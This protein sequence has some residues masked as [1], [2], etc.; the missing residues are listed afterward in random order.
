MTLN[1][2][3]EK[4]AM[5]C[6]FEFCTKIYKRETIELMIDCFSNLLYSIIEN[7]DQKLKDINILSQKEKDKINQFNN[8]SMIIDKN[9]TMHQLFEEQVKRHP[10]KLQLYTKIIR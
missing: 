10:I 4:N 7:I 2:T 5:N 8:K 1:I 6:C 9:K 3:E